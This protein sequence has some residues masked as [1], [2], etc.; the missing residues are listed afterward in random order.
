MNS[1]ISTE[2]IYSD[3]L[4]KI[5]NLELSPGSMI[6]ENRICDE[7][8]VSRST[9]R[10]VFAR[11][12]QIDF[13]TIY[14]QRGTY[15]NKIDLDYLKNALIIRVALEKEMLYRLLKLEDKTEFIEKMKINIDKQDKLYANK[16]DTKDFD[17]LDEEFHM[18]ILAGSEKNN[19]YSMTEVYFLHIARWKN[20]YIKSGLPIEQLV[21]EHKQIFNSI[22][23]NS[24]VKAL[25]C[26][27][28]HIHTVEGMMGF[29]K[30]HSDYF[31]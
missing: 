2:E 26:I 17:K 10:N 1:I 12:S 21:Y 24:L 16:S 27:S 4:K 8:N 9:I 28:N 22:K 29:I 11:L 23:E 20:L 18:H 19:I 30:E 31:K 5:I 6:S 7:Y 14:P 15:V 25:E 13:I 3:I